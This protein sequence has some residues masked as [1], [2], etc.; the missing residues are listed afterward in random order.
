[1]ISDHI[2]LVIY[3]IAIIIPI[4]AE[5]EV[6]PPGDHRTL[7]TCSLA[8]SFEEKMHFCLSLLTMLFNH[9]LHSTQ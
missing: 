1:M 3:S 6:S 2:I 7:T 4:A 5:W 9:G 8:I